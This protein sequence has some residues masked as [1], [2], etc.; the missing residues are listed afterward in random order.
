MAGKRRL[1][2]LLAT[3]PAHPNL[4]TATR[5]AEAA[6][7]HDTEVYFYCIDEGV[8]CVDTPPVQG[9]ATQGVHLFACA[10]GAQKRGLPITDRASYAGLVVL[11]D[12]MKGCDRFVVFS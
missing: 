5:L 4:E 1:G 11:S 7:A 3:P 2:M 9:L 8:A 6:V 12:M 10:Y